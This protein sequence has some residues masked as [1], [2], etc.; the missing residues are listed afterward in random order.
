MQYFG[1]LLLDVRSRYLND[2]MGCLDGIP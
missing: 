1:D 2:S